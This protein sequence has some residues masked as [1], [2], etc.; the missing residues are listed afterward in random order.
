ME[1]IDKIIDPKVLE[2]INGYIKRQTTS[3]PFNED[4]IEHLKQLLLNLPSGD[5]PSNFNIELFI[6]TYRDVE[7]KFEELKSLDRAVYAYI[8]ILLGKCLN[9]ITG[10]IDKLETKIKTETSKKELRKQYSDALFGSD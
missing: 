7:N 8:C 9:S 10:Y 2:K 1:D 4:D 6:S 3:G 5:V